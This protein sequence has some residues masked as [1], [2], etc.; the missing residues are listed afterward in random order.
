ML[1]HWGC[2]EEDGDGEASVAALTRV[3]AAGGAAAAGQADAED[4]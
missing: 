3:A 1:L 4:D 2:A